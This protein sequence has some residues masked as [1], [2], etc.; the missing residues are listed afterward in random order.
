MKALTII[1]PYAEL[2][3][4]GEKRVENRTWVTPGRGRI[5]IHAG[6]AKKYAGQPVKDIAAR[7]GLDPATLQFGAII[8]M[9]DLIDCVRIDHDPS[10]ATRIAD[11]AYERH[12]WLLAHEH[13]EGPYGFILA[14]VQRVKPVPM[15]G[16]LGFWDIETVCNSLRIPVPILE[17][18][19]GGR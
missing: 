16:A 9:A 11:R 10:G 7:Y 14:N 13:A 17:P 19:G 6:V 3:A 2:I 12:P 15:R 4:R 5:A 18:I 8:A 1:Q